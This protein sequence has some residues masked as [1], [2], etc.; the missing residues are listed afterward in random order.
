[1]NKILCVFAM[2]LATSNL[3]S[4]TIPFT[5]GIVTDLKTGEPLVGATVSLFNGEHFDGI[6]TNKEG[7]FIFSGDKKYDSLKISM[8][9]YQSKVFYLKEIINK[10]PISVKLEQNPALLAEVLVKPPLAV[11]IVKQAIAKISFFQPQNNIENKGFYREIIKDKEQ[12]FSVAEAMLTAQYFP[13]KQSYKL[14]MDRGRSK[15]DVGY[16]R[17]FEDFHPGGGPQAAAENSFIIKRP[18]FLNLKKINLFNYKIEKMIRSDDQELYCIAFDQKPG[19]KEALEKGEIYIDADDYAIV[20]Y[21][22]ANSPAGTPYVKNLTGTDKIFAEILNIDFKRKGWTRTIDFTKLNGKLLMSH[23]RVEYKIGYQQPKK[24]IDLD[25][26]INVEL[27]MTDLESKFT[28]EIA[29]EEEWKRK[30]LAMNLPSAFDSAY[31][32]NNNIISPTEEIKQI[33]ATI[34]KN[35]HDTISTIA[36]GGW[37]YMNQNLFMTSLQQDTIILIPLM[38]SLW[39]EDQTGSMIFK[40]MEGDFT[41]ESKIDIT[42]M[43]D[44][45]QMPDKG[46]QQ[47]GIIV[48]N[49]DDKKENYLILSMGTGG[50]SNPKIFFKKTIDNKTRTVVSKKDS[51]RGWLRIDKKGT[52]I[53]AFYKNDKNADWE[54]TGELEIGWLKGKLQLGL[55]VFANFSSDGPKMKPDIKAAFSQLKIDVI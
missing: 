36:I 2:I 18:D 12:Y 5:N 44:G 21:E 9:G 19:V 33:I 3:I 15:E 40:N 49:P 50:N 43:S 34:S 4:Q 17:L 20:K 22:A 7:K 39:E 11:D 27:L 23:A 32:G 28:K 41:I 25:L 48:R 29:K 38:K 35:N 1:M 51:T 10:N 13:S 24:N 47:A 52:K 55:M 45:S 53:D 14:K 30:N 8:I 37:Q 42:K 54:K 31:W 6:T 26:T 46:F 16:T